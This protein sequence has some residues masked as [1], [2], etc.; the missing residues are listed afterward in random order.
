MSFA[1]ELRHE[2]PRP[3]AGAAITV[4]P[5]SQCRRIHPDRTDQ[6]SIAPYCA[7]TAAPPSATPSAARE[8]PVPD[9]ESRDPSPPG[10]CATARRA[11]RALCTLIAGTLAV[12]LMHGPARADDCPARAEEL[13]LGTDL[14]HVKAAIR[15][16]RQVVIVALGSSSTQG[17][18]ATIDTNAYPAQAQVT[19][20]R[21]YETVR[22][23]FVMLNRGAGGQ[24]VTE[25]LERLQR[26]VLSHRPDL[27]IWQVGTNAAIRGMKLDSFRLK[28]SSGI[29]RMK[30]AGTDVVLMTP[31]YSP[32]IVALP[33]EDDY[34]A[35][36]HDVARQTGAGVFRRFDIMR[37]WVMRQHMPFGRFM[38]ADGLHLNDYGQRCTGQLLAR[39][40]ERTVG[41]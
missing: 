23:K 18:G 19:L 7:A 2:R 5:P 39:A 8:M 29:E 24:D 3:R 11:A 37:G 22:L 21:Q 32:A 10:A 14:P 6:A 13:R 36:M 41:D 12:L 25:M 1:S 31:Q 17:Y 30:Q 27:V 26:D 40:I 16:R 35:A 20:A 9:Q 34:V 15:E 4:A 38:I 28:L 33:N